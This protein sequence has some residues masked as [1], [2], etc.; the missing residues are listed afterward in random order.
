M[1][2]KAM[3]GKPAVKVDGAKID[4]KGSKAETEVKVKAETEVEDKIQTEV[5]PEA[6]KVEVKPKSAIKPVEVKVEPVTESKEVKPAVSA[7]PKAAI[8]TPAGTPTPEP[9][10]K[11]PVTPTLDSLQEELNL[12]KRLVLTHNQQIVELQEMVTELQDMVSRKRKPTSNGKVQIRDKQTGNIY[13]SKNNCYKSLLKAGDLKDLIAK[14]VFGPDPE[15][16]TFGW[17]ALVRALPERFE[18]IKPPETTETTKP[19]ETTETPKDKSEKVEQADAEEKPNSV[20][21]D[22]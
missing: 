6:A 14:R 1:E 22:K 10:I 3:V 11:K 4:P 15:K 5:K 18:E 17:Y 13:P 16:N 7:T 19:I 9:E 8:E 21:K 2:S 20:P 12:L